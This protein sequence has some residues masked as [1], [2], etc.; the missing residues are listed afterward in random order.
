[1]NTTVKFSLRRAKVPVELEAENGGI[2]KYFLIEM[3]GTQRDDFLSDSA[4]RMEVIPG[5]VDEKGNPKTRIKDYKGLYA[6]LLVV[7]MQDEKGKAPTLE[8]V[9]SWPARVQTELYK[10]AQELNKLN[11][12][13]E[14]KGKN[15]SP[16]NA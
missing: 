1:M 10:L 12:K 14:E 3:D 9:Q 2:E 5:E 15:A 4:S 8:T 7:C 16:A 13:E 6:K 11:E